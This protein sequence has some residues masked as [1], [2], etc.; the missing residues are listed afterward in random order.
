MAA[1][2]PGTDYYVNPLSYGIQRQSNK[3][4]AWAGGF[5]LGPYD[6]NE[7]QAEI[8]GLKHEGVGGTNLPGGSASSAQQLGNAG[9]LTGVDAI[10]A[11]F[12]RLTNKNTWLRVAEFGVGGMMLYVASKAMFP[13]TVSTVTGPVK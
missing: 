9:S 10:G 6:W 2:H 7:A 4:L 8:A 3:A 12:N 11:F 1:P 13:G 5:V